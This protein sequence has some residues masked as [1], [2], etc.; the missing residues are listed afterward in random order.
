M[1]TDR[2]FIGV[3]VGTGSARAGVF[4]ADGRLLGTARHDI[5]IWREGADLVEQSSDDIWASCAHAV[6]AAVAQAAVSADAVCGLSFDATCSLVL[7]DRQMCPLAAGTSGDAAR[8]IIVWMDHRAA[9]QARAINATGDQVLDFVGG[10]ISPEMQTPKLLWLK[11]HLPRTFDAAGQFLDLTDYLTWRATGSLARSVCTV[12]C[13]WTYLAHERRWSD[14][15]FRRIGLGEIVD[16]GY[17][18][19]GTEIV[20]PGTALAQGLT[21]AAAAVFGLRAGTPVGAGLIDAH[22]GGVG[23]IGGRGQDGTPQSAERRIA[24][25]MGTSACAMAVT[26][27]Q[28]FVPGV[29]G[30]YYSAMIPG[31][32]LAEG[33]QSAAGAAIDFLVRLHPAYAATAAE[34]EQRGTSV[35]GVL[36]GEAMARAGGASAVALLASSVHVLP[37]FLGNR[38]P[39][40]DPDARAV[41]AGLPLDDSRDGLLRLYVAGLCGLGYGAAQILDALAGQDI[42]LDTIVMSGGAAKSPLTR[43]IIADATGLSVVLPET[44]EPVLLGAAM[45]GAVAAGAVAD[46]GE[47]MATLSRDA[48]TTPPARG[49][50]AAFHA[51]KRVVFAEMQ[52]LDRR[53]REVMVGVGPA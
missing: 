10:A 11:Q 36:E 32:W 18:R 31:L 30:P 43:Q 16:G 46:L 20:E 22:A 49:R 35:L 17:V 53:A 1:A 14:A 41:L 52:A 27:T 40:A 5:R 8:N 9:E 42:A 34:A 45:L 28:R 13:K 3:D 48:T 24:F 39:F 7:L 33:G 4:S 6:R 47:A 15:Y 19:I 37:D 2:C 26:R 12:T 25:I 23:S 51:A 21:L 38:S 29:W 50:V 44:A